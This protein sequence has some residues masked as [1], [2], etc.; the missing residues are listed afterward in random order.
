MNSKYQSKVKLRYLE[1]NDFV[2]EV[3]VSWI[4]NVEPKQDANV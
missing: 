2:Y 4:S 1:I 3:S